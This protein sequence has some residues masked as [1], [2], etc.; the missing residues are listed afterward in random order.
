MKH[1][2]HELPI[3]LKVE[4]AQAVASILHSLHQGQPSIIGFLLED[5]RAHALFMEDFIQQDVLIFAEQVQFQMAY[6]PWHSVTLNV[7]QAADRLIEDLGF[8]PPPY[9]FRIV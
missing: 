8:C 7:E 3:R 1:P 9:F 4:M 6:D 5:L 2:S